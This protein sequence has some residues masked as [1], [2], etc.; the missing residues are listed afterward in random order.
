MVYNL[1]CHVEDRSA[2]NYAT[3]IVR[4]MEKSEP[5]WSKIA[6]RTLVNILT[7]P[8][9]YAK[10][11]IQIGYEPLEPRQTTTLFGRPALGLPNIFQ[12]VK[13]IKNIDGLSGCYRGLAPK[14]CG[15]TIY[16]I[17]FDKSLKHIEFTEEDRDPQENDTP[18]DD[19]PDEL[20]DKKYVEDFFKNLIARTVGI[21][22]SHP[23]D[24]ISVRMMAQFVGGETKYIT[25]VGSVGTIY[26]ENGISGF[27]AGLLPR[28]LAHVATLA[29]VSTSTYLINKYIIKD[30]DMRNFTS[31]TMTFLASTVTYPFL[32]VSQ[33]MIVNNCGLA[34][35]EPPM[36]P[37]YVDWLDCWHHLSRT[38]QLKRGSSLLWRYYTGPQTIIGGRMYADKTSLFRKIN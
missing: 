15:L 9:D 28:L 24:V 34:A 26:K 21:I 10:V 29:V 18:V 23:F 35:G 30:R 5:L 17:V 25:I 6:C 38:R 20:R 32:V 22:I 8:F 19:L 3:G 1:W 33:C 13:Y 11:L 36:M 31:A 14:L 4:I 16:A 37:I 7:H 27:F 12:Y 2:P